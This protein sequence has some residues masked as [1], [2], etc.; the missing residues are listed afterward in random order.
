MRYFAF[1]ASL[2]ALGGIALAGLEVKRVV[3]SEP[4][5]TVVNPNGVVQNVA[6]PQPPQ[7][8]SAQRWPAAFG[9]IVVAEPQPPAPV[10]APAPAPPTP[11]SPP[12]DALGYVLSG[13]VELNGSVWAIVSHAT[14]QSVLKVGDQLSE[15]LTVVKIDA[16]GLWV[17]STRGRELLAFGE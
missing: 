3:Q 8:L 14:G 2:L 1:L 11:Q 17:D 7:S 6:E 13:T 16:E 10:E 12:I 9:D 5:A 4:L 15:G